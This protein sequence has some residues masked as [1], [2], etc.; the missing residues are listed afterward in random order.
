MC[1]AAASYSSEVCGAE[2]APITIMFNY[3]H[4]HDYEYEFVELNPDRG[5]RV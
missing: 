3:E 1:N 4:E 2:R 5:S